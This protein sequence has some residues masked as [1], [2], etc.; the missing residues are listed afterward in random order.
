M[1]RTVICGLGVLALAA[2]M[3]SAATLGGHTAPSTADA[4]GTTTLGV[5]VNT[6]GNDASHLGTIDNCRRVEASDS[7]DV[8]VF[9]KDVS[10]AVP[11]QG[12][13][14]YVGFDS[15]RLT[16][17]A[18]NAP[19]MVS[20]LDASDPVPDSTGKHFVGIGATAPV[21]GSG[22]LTRLTFQASSQGSANIV[23]V[24][25][26]PYWPILSGPSGY[27]GDT[28][29]DHYFDGP[30]VNARVA[31]GQD[32]SAGTPPVTN[33][34]APTVTLPPTPT[35]SPS[36]TTVPTQTPP[37]TQG[38]SLTPTPTAAPSQT[39]FPTPTPTS[40]LT[41]VGD[42]DCSGIVG[43][44]DVLPALRYASKVGPVSTCQGRTD[45]DCDG[46]VTANDVLRIL[47]YVA[48]E[49]LPQPSGCQPIGSA[50]S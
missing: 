11:L 24:A 39:P 6:D 13:D 35:P 42:A 16:L 21:S 45:T 9:V 36:P 49:P 1:R 40:S 44:P 29:S 8:D 26:F 12:F 20:G 33:S 34:P 17:T 25:A 50:V 30:I 4:A 48:G 37:Q 32:C 3:L 5:D 27:P 10:D 14:I 18:Q 46:F 7:V 23:I 15:T 31:I 28:N 43:L 38:P 47:R 41:I 2:A 19:H 22:V